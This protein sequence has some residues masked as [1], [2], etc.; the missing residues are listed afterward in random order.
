MKLLLSI[1]NLGLSQFISHRKL[2]INWYKIM[3]GMPLTEAEKIMGFS[4]KL[5]SENSN[6]RKVYSHNTKDHLPFYIVVDPSS[7]NIIRKHNIRALDELY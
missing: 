4:F 2:R 1:K 3:V 7:G 6:G 5:D